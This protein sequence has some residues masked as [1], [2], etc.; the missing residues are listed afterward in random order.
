MSL[1]KQSGHD[2][3]NLIQEIA[4]EDGTAVILVTHNN[5]I[6]DAADRILHLEDGNMKSRTE[7]VSEDTSRMLNLLEKHEPESAS[8]LASFAFSLALVAIPTAGLQPMSARP[9]A[10]HCLK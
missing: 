4:R 3:V 10:E 9:F 1:D 6:L 5:C 7:V 2:V 8:L